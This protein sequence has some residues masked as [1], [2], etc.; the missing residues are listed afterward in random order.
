MR[1]T[2]KINTACTRQPA[3]RD[4]PSQTLHRPW[5]SWKASRRAPSPLTCWCGD[6]TCPLGVHSTAGLRCS[7]ATPATASSPNNRKSLTHPH[8]A[9]PHPRQAQRRHLLQQGHGRHRLR[10]PRR[11]L[12]P[13]RRLR[14]HAPHGHPGPEPLERLRRLP[15]R[16]PR[17]PHH[18]RLRQPRPQQGGC[19][20]GGA[21]G[22]RV[23][24]RPPRPVNV[25]AAGSAPFPLRQGGG[26]RCAH[27][28]DAMLRPAACRCAG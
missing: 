25:G 3:L 12:R 20:A 11:R 17:G 19:A 18:R 28:I 6:S 1:L 13:H 23:S 27:R 26:K 24:E 14:Q 22:P 15:R 8:S 2:A 21:R 10:R 9:G 7:T 4:L 5:G 16:R